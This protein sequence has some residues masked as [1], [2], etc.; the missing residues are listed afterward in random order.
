MIIDPV[1]W[2]MAG[3]LPENV[4]RITYGEPAALSVDE[5]KRRQPERFKQ[6]LP[7]NPDPDQYHVSHIAPYKI[8]QRCAPKMRVGRVLLVGDAAHVQNPFSG[9]GLTCGMADV[10]GVA[11]CLIGI[12]K[13]VAHESILDKYDEVRRKIYWDVSDPVSSSA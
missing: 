7:G 12:N 5:C 3:L 6:M 4:W 10:G 1:N 8:H 2:Y 13:G 11:D 9:L